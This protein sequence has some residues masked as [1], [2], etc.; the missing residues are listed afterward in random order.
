M[1]SVPPPNG[2]SVMPLNEIP[3]YLNPETRRLVDA[4]LED[5]CQELKKDACVHANPERMKMATTIV[6]LASI[7]E[8]DP[9]KLKWFAI[10]TVR[11]SRQAKAAKA[12]RAIAE[13]IE[14]TS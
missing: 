14:T 7:G 9:A 13:A 5:A 2:E 4:T 6:A 3:K 8:T 12:K 11:G 10:N 1:S